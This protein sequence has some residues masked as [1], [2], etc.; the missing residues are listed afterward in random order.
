MNQIRALYALLF[1]TLGGMGAWVWKLNDRQGVVERDLRSAETAKAVALARKDKE[2]EEALAAQDAR[3]QED[4]RKLGAD[5]EAKLDD[6]SKRERLKLAQA[7]EQFSSILDGDRKTLDYINLIEQKVKSGQQISKAEAEN[8]AVI[9]T[10][11][12]YLQKQYAKPFED[13]GELEAYLQKRAVTPIDTPNMRNSFWKRMFS[14]EFREK[15]RE[16]YRSEG[17]RRGFQDAQGRFA[18]AYAAAQK[19]MAGVNLEMDKTLAQLGDIIREKQANA[20]DLS[21]FFTQA[22]KALGAHQK[23]L[24]FEPEPAKPVIEGAKP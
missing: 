6:F 10:G 19:R 14:H 4:M 8:L 16:F 17:E 7:Y 2:H 21:G 23:L 9:A 20:P 24:E 13:F 3:H 5:Y 15:E 22:R 12:T 18:D 11:L 1:L